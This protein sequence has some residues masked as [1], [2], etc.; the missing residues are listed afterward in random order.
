MELFVFLLFVWL[1]LCAVVAY[2]AAQKGR[3]GIGMFFLSLFL[4]PLVGLLVTI[5]LPAIRSQSARP[6]MP[7]SESGFALCPSCGRPRRVDRQFCPHCRALWPGPSPDPHAGEKKCPACAEWIK[8]EATKC[9]YCGEVQPAEASPPAV[10]IG[11][12]GYCPGCG[13]IRNS[14]APGC[15]F[16][17]ST[18]PVVAERPNVAGR[19]G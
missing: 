14:T 19:T 17:R 9:R 18:A 10:T 13:Q 11:F 5:A 16:C 7:Q 4:S 2:V 6:G 8:Q 12:L 15:V 1:P 3:S